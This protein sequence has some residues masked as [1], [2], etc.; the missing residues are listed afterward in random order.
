MG[1]KSKK[2][3]KKGGKGGGNKVRVSHIVVKKHSEALQILSRIREGERFGNLAEECSDCPS[4][5]RKG[6]L[7]WFP[8]GKMHKEF[9][10]AAFALNIGAMTNE[11]VRSPA[12]YHIIKRTG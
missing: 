10:D 6:D 5:K 12:G 9:E 7:G 11:P 4:S 2:G 3:K 8:R 1:K